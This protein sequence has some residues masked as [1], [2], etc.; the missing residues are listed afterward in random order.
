LVAS[1]QQVHQGLSQMPRQPVFGGAPGHQPLAPR[2]RRAILLDLPIAWRLT[3]GFLLA[4]V[5][6]AAAAGVPAFQRAQSLSSESS[7][8]QSLLQWNTTLTTGNNLVQLMDTEVHQT[9]LDASGP[10]LSRETLTTDQAAVADLESRYDAILISFVQSGLLST[11]AEEISLL[12]E[13][14]HGGEVLQQ[15]TLTSSAMRTWHV[16]RAAQ[17]AV[18]QTI[19]AGNV[20]AAN[21]LERAQGEPT[22]ADALSALR[23]LIQFDGRIAASVHDVANVEQQYQLITALVAAVLAFLGIGAVGWVISETLVRRLV[24]LQSVTHAVGQGRIETRVRVAGRD[25]VAEVSTSVNGMLDT[26]VGLLD[27]AQRQRDALVTAAER[28]FSDVRIA[29]SGDLRVNASVSADPIGLLGNAFNL[30][31]GRFRRFAL[32]SQA[33]VEQMDV[34]ARQL[35]DRASIYVTAAH[36]I[37][38]GAGVVGGARAGWE[39]DAEFDRH[40]EFVRSLAEAAIARGTA[41]RAEV[42][43][44]LA[45]RAHLSARRLYQLA[46]SVI[47]QLPQGAD[48]GLAHAQI[49]EIRTLG[50]VLARLG[51]EAQAALTSGDVNGSTLVEAVDRLGVLARSGASG[52]LGAQAVMGDPDG[53]VVELARLI[54]NFAQEADALARHVGYITGDLRDGLA[55][56]RL[57]AP[58]GAGQPSYPPSGF[59]TQEPYAIAQQDAGYGSHSA[60]N[61]YGAPA[62]TSQPRWH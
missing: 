40:L 48:N 3:L 11:H 23:A 46:A 57:G 38:T 34:A 58:G 35:H 31:V 26:I 41:G 36:H 49:E 1:F 16:Y 32:R 27:T 10:N 12:S 4:A 54:Q 13:A 33:T 62:S 60:P 25:E 37:T 44:D 7:F 15:Q 22:N 61:P 19:A 24:A 53:Q 56:F 42:V 9:L 55:S 20:D 30:T 2:S 8:Y 14:N 50:G 6:A 45:Q 52:T 21:T 39:A 17:G 43:L 59:G 28:L 18:M 47:S 29:G 51:S 5:I